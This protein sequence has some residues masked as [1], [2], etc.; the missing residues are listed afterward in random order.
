MWPLGHPGPFFSLH[1]AL[2]MS[3]RCSQ[4]VCG[5]RGGSAHVPMQV[6]VPPVWSWA[7]GA[8]WPTQPLNLCQLH[9]Y[10]QGVWGC[11]TGDLYSL[12]T[13]PALLVGTRATTQTPCNKEGEGMAGGCG[14]RAIVGS[15]RKCGEQGFA[16]RPRQPK[17]PAGS[18]GG[19]TR[20]GGAPPT[21]GRG[22][23]RD[24]PPSAAPMC[25][26]TAPLG[27]VC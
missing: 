11:W 5:A 18:L 15:T 23:R 16:Q 1:A 22:R 10:L 19:R 21:T 25:A 9:C 17:A 14:A 7:T 2:G 26:A 3:M 24:S 12:S 27:G 13:R 4:C 6:P 8:A 20:P